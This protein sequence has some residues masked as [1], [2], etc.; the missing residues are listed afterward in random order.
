VSIPEKGWTVFDIPKCE[1]CG[2][3]IHR[4]Y[5][6]AKHT[7]SEACREGVERI[8]QRKA[9]V[10]NARALDVSFT[11]YDEE[12]ERVEV[13]KYLGRLMSMDDNDRA[14]LRRHASAGRCWEDWYV[15]RIC[16]PGSAECSIRLLFKRFCCMVAKLGP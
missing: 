6:N 7:A 12:L 14:N 3:Q 10:E 8:V 11:A 9:A 15:E 2:M 5:L 16:P 4:R 13:F 1:R